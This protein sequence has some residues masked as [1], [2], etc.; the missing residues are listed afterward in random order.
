V[1]TTAIPAL[2]IFCALLIAM[3]ALAI[4]ANDNDGGWPSA[5]GALAMFVI[6][7]YFA[8]EQLS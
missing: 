2:V 4:S 6:A 8:I 7:I 5:V 1:T 3:I